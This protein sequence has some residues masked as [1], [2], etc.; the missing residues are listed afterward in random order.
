MQA[1]VFKGDYQAG[2]ECLYSGNDLEAARRIAYSAEK[3]PFQRVLLSWDKIT[4]FSR[5]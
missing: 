5:Y 4:I 2:W 1:Q 3:E